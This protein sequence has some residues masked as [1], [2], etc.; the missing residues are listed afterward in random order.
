MSSGTVAVASAPASPVLDVPAWASPD[1][2][3]GLL[4][5]TEIRA[6]ITHL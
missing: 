2:L 6:S 3:A 5:F 4:T 1:P